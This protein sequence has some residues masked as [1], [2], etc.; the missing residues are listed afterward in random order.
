MW[1]VR[2][3]ALR[4]VDAHGDP[5]SSKEYL[6]NALNEVKGHSDAIE[7]KNRIRR[8]ITSFFLDRDCFTMVRPTE[9]EKDLQHL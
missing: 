7:A 2:D 4:M 3:F 9:N 1:I 8:M 6:E 5:V